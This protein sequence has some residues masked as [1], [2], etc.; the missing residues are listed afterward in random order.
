MSVSRR[1]VRQ[2][3]TLA[4]AATLVAPAWAQSAPA[5]AVAATELDQVVVTGARP[6]GYAVP[7][8]YPRLR[9]IQFALA[10]GL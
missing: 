6:A 9:A 5:G 3:L 10:Y 8:T 1:H 2:R 4:I 7:E